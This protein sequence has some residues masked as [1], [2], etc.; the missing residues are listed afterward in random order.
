MQ[1]LIKITQ[2]KPPNFLVLTSLL[3]IFDCNNVITLIQRSKDISIMTMLSKV[4]ISVLESDQLVGFVMAMAAFAN[5][6]SYS[7]LRIKLPK[8]DI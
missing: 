7:W 2:G 3:H 5:T 4:D 8:C 1:F 6:E